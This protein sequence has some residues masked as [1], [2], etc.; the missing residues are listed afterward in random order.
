[1][2]VNYR[3]S[4]PF[5]I[6]L[7]AWLNLGIQIAFP[8]ATTFTPAVAVTSSKDIRFLQN[9]AETSLKTVPYVLS[10]DETTASVA[11][12]FNMSPDALQK[13]NQFRTFAH[14]FYHLKPGD[15]LEVPLAPLPEV[16]WQDAADN[17][18]KLN[19]NNGQ[20]QKLAE[21]ANQAGTILSS[22]ESSDAATGM[23][24]GMVTAEASSQ[25]QQWLSQFGTARVQL[26][27]D[28]NFSLK[29]SQFDLL[30][31]LYE[32]ADKLLFTQGSLHRTDDRTQ[33]NLGL[34]YRWFSDGWMLGANSFLD[35]D[36]S[37]D[38]SRIG[39]GLEYWRDFLKFGINSYLRLSNW[40]NSPN[41]KDYEERPANGWDIRAQGWLPALP[42][43]GGK[44]S[45]EQYYGNDVALFGRNS[46]QR[47]P[48]AINAEVNYTPVPLITFSAG[49]RQGKSSKN[50]T[51]LGVELNYRLG[52]PWQHQVNP[53]AV[54]AMR[55]L[56]GSRYE[57]VD[58]NNNIVLEY[59]KKETI[60]L[61]TAG[62]VSGFPGEQK[63]LEVV[64]SSQY[65]L[66]RIDWSAPELVAAGGS[67]VQ[68]NAAGYSVILPDWKVG[69]QDINSYTISGVAID[70]KGNLSTHAN[71]QVLVQTPVINET[72]ST[73]LPTFSNMMVGEINKETLTLTIKDEQGRMVNV[74]ASEIQIG[75]EGVISAEVSEVVRKDVGIYEITITAGM[76]E[77]NI[78][79]TP[80]VRG[81]TLPSAQVYI[82]HSKPT[83]SNSFISVDNMTYEATN[84]IRVNV[85]LA[86][87]HGNKISGAVSMLTESAVTVENAV[88]INEWTESGNGRYTRL[89]TATRAGTNLKAM[90]NFPNGSVESEA[91]E[92]TIK[93]GAVNVYGEQV[94]GGW[95]PRTFTITF[96]PDEGYIFDPA[97]FTVTGIVGVKGWQGNPVA[98]WGNTALNH[99]TAG[100]YV[101]SLSVSNRCGYPVAGKVV[102]QLFRTDAQNEKVYTSVSIDSAGA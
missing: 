92:I 21:W 63:S 72:H 81:I 15:E 22:N 35:Y 11:H 44:L 95:Y 48:H 56:A 54:T 32:H 25:I 5:R 74:P 85:S 86:D 4:V 26:D 30:V 71:T 68:D 91:Y 6:K 39:L 29:N 19:A 31:P 79:L 33:S 16:I 14:G 64:V 97:C 69:A 89:Y 80:V 83:Q 8:L 101:W 73:F 94:A 42:Q 60:N 67:I 55:K 40:K 100:R 9:S 43:L 17:A 96:E 93:A 102:T 27:A 90:L 3:L 51:R 2:N 13:L 58:R 75:V 36:L 62:L 37:R 70:K 49:Q 77:E 18:V 66:E 28:E 34:G 45:F 53:H 84:D 24:R 47:D 52:I 46:R 78:I 20:E 38:H 65:G 82:I 41:V 61:S 7:F 98:G 23:A 59:R 88:A 57:L 10:G 12:K 99:N 1:M 50:D 76:D 87:K